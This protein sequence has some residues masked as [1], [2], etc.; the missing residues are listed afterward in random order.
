VPAFGR[1]PLEFIFS[2]PVKDET[3]GFICNRQP[4]KQEEMFDYVGKIESEELGQNPISITLTGRALVPALKVKPDPLQFGECPVND[5]RDVVV[6]LHNAQE[7]M[8]LDFSIPRVPHISVEPNSG[9]LAPLQNQTVVVSF[10]PKNLG[11]FTQTV[12]VEYCNG[13]YKHLLKCYGHAPVVGEKTAPVK[14]LEKNW[15]GFCSRKQVCKPRKHEPWN[16]P[17]EESA[18]PHED[19]EVQFV[20]PQRCITGS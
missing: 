3:T 18:E 17:Q 16:A 9:K 5:R 13:L 10:T 12:V 7:D 2:P 6:T 20:G 19:H 15:Q 1:I 14:G 8:P 4:E 11:K